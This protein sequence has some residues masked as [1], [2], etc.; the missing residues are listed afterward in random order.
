MKPSACA[1]PFG[2]CSIAPASP[3]RSHDRERSVAA[4]GSQE[5]DA[6]RS[7]SEAAAVRRLLAAKDEDIARI[8]VSPGPINEPQLRHDRDG[9]GSARRLPPRPRSGRS[10]AQHLVLSPGAR[11]P[12]ARR[13]L[14]RGRRHGDPDGTGG[15]ELQAKLVTT[16]ASPASAHRPRSR[17]LAEP[18]RR[19]GTRFQADGR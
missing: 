18:S 19:W 2:R 16:S 6:G 9:H 7:A 5:G 10:R 15:S 3:G 17:H 4:A 11:R 1:P 8:F 14:A 13:G 12:A